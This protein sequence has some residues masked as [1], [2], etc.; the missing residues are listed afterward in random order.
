MH[1]HY[2]CGGRGS[3]TQN[4]P[5]L[6][7]DLSR[8]L[9]PKNWGQEITDNNIHQSKSDGNE[10]GSE[11][12]NIKGSNDHETQ[13]VQKAVLI[14]SSQKSKSRVRTHWTPSSNEYVHIKPSTSKWSLV[15]VICLCS[16][17]CWL[18]FWR[19]IFCFARFS[20]QILLE[21]WQLIAC[22]SA[23][24]MQEATRASCMFPVWILPVKKSAFKMKRSLGCSSLLYYS[25]TCL[26]LANI[27][28]L[29]NGLSFCF[30]NLANLY[31]E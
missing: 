31:T 9:M 14:L 16:L 24:N 23:G 17:F 12:K 6:V 30:I 27:S 4:I 15:L 21:W 26:G 7:A 19:P 25:L 11:D 5:F 29:F 3:S 18:M 20:E 28:K 10:A 2:W 13:C 1:L 8:S 22:P